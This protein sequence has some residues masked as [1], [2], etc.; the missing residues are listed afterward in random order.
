MLASM[1]SKSQPPVALVTGAS[2]GLGRGIAIELARAGMS[3]GIHYAGNEIA[4]HETVAACIEV[5]PHSELQKF[6]PLQADIGESAEREGLFSAMLAT[7]G[8]LDALINNAGITSIGRKDILEATEE[9]FDRVMDVNLKA[10][11][12]LAKSAGN[13]WLENP[14]DSRLV[15][16]YKLVFIGSVSADTAS[17]NRGDYCLS[18]AALGMANHLWALRLAEVAQVIELRPG[19]MATDMTSAAKEKYDSIIEKGELI[20]MRR[21][22][23]G[24]DVGRG[25]AS[26]LRNDWPFSTG[27]VIS[28]DGGMHLKKL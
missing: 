16:G 7:F 8:R 1:N 28:I 23:N 5:A 26:F 22:G 18:K 21:W 24:E 6:E 12:F 2:R 14:R 9:S 15:G 17:L 13:Y 3:I 11:Y 10:P 20:P 19:V 25:V 27:E 4:A